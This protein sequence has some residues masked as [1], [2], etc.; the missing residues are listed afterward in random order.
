MTQ[1]QHRAEMF[2]YAALGSPLLLGA[3]VSK[4]DSFS[5]SLLTAPEVLAV[6]QDRECVQGSRVRTRTGGEIWAKPLSDKTFAV[7]LLNPLDRPQ[8]ITVLFDYKENDGEFMPV[9]YDW[10]DPV[11]I[12]DLYERRDLGLF[13]GAFTATV[14]AMDAKIF[15]FTPMGPGPSA[16]SPRRSRARHGPR[17]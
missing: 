17:F 10:F 7:T 15:K 3:D 2:V 14:P 8:N 12:R 9:D 6:N 13:R 16:G 1:S 11:R 4:L 5:V